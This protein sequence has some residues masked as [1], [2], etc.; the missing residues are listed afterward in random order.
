MRERGFPAPDVLAGPLALGPGW[1]VAMSY[2]RSGSP[3]N[4]TRLPVRRMMPVGLARLVAEADDLKELDGLPRKSFPSRDAIW[5]KPHNALFDFEVTR[6]GAQWIDD[7]AGEALA[8]L[9]SACSRIVL[10]HDDW[11]AKNMRMHERSIAVV[12]DWDSVFV[13]LETVFLGTAAAHSR[14]RGNWMFCK[15]RR[16]GRSRLS[17]V[18]TNRRAAPHSTEPKS[19][20]ERRGRPMHEPIR[21]VANTRWTRNVMPGAVRRA[22]A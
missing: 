7:I 9:Q 5:P 20:K 15:P 18:S 14:S 3:T 17:C 10:G 21:R 16:P 19:P 1:A 11:S 22:R 6:Q 8:I 13:G 4:A 2:D 12:Y